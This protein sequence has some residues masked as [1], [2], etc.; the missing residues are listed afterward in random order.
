MALGGESAESME[1][2]VTEASTRRTNH[3]RQTR[4]TRNDAVFRSGASVLCQGSRD[5]SRRADRSIRAASTRAL[6]SK[7]FEFGARGPSSSS[8]VDRKMQMKIKCL[9]EFLFPEEIPLRSVRTV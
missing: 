3:R 6:L 7:E 1:F 5:L 4:S 8:G 2:T 9:C